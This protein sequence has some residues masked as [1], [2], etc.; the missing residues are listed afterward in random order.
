MVGREEGALA[1]MKEDNAELISYHCVIHQSVLCSTLSDE[2]AEVMNT[3]IRR[4][5]CLGVSHLHGMLCEML[6]DVD[7]NSNDLLLHN[8]VRWLSKGRVL[9]RFWP[10]R[11]DT[12]IFST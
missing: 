10:I 5:N 3:M 11:T 7:A 6:R 2:H 4:I 1:R 12:A 8:D 9:E